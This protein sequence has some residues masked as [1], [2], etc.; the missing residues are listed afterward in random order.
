MENREKFLANVVWLIRNSNT[1]YYPIIDMIAYDNHAEKYKL[2]IKNET[3]EFKAK[4]ELELTEKIIN[5]MSANAVTVAERLDRLSAKNN[6][7]HD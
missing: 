4:S 3:I 2:K 1:E 6:A 5:I 7:N